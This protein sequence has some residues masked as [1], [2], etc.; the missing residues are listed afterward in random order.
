MQNLAERL[1]G[2]ERVILGGGIAFLLFAIIWVRTKVGPVTKGVF[3]NYYTP[4][5][6]IGVF[7]ATILFAII[8][9]LI[10][11]YYYLTGRV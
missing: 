8:G 2:A 6:T 7:T 1:T 3:K 5:G 9:I 10:V 4:S 11:A